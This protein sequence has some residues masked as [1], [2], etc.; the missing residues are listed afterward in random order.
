MPPS[1]FLQFDTRSELQ[2]PVLVRDNRCLFCFI[3]NFLDSIWYLTLCDCGSDLIVPRYYSVY[4]VLVIL[5]LLG[6]SE[7]VSYRFIFQYFSHCARVIVLGIWNWKTL[8]HPLHS[9]NRSEE[10][11]L[12]PNWK[13]DLQ[14]NLT[15]AR[16]D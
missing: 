5:F 14:E 15:N 7:S 9:E 10:L 16:S 12:I 1:L 6:N 13:T 11:L 3:N 4:W 8:N 2:E